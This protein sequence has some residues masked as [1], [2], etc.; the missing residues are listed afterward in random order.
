MLKTRF[1]TASILLPLVLLAIVYLPPFYFSFFLAASLMMGAW[2][3]S[4]LVGFSFLWLRVIYV[5]S[6]FLGLLLFGFLL[7]MAYPFNAGEIQVAAPAVNMSAA[8]FSS[9]MQIEQMI[10]V[11]VLV[12]FLTWLWLFAGILSYQKNGKGFGFAH[13][14]ARSV[15][16]FIVLVTTW[17]AM[18]TL[19]VHPGFGSAWLIF[20]LLLIM[21][22][23]V[24]AYFSG[25]HFGK[26]A[27]ASRVSPK[28]TWAGFVG[29]ILSS[30]LIA[31][32]GG[33]FF[34]LTPL[35]YFLFLI[36]AVITAL[37]SVVGDLG[38]SL[39]KR[40][41]G[42]KDTGRII[43][44]HGGVLDRLDS[45]AAATVVFV[46]LALWLGVVI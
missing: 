45:I 14:I 12:G 32:L 24:G 6:I 13:P 33:S 38:V 20:V 35:S 10:W 7:T 5:I 17:V 1:I 2:E 30:L 15:V 34:H 43:P 44:G 8:G 3:W 27:L 18:M 31:M 26:R 9:V 37:F 4:G 21:G 16:G 28:K 25:R 46:L 11:V 29:G 41:S 42:I 40:I 39:L 19:R 22:V 36:V 23:D